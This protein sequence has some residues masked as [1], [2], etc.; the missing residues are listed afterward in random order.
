MAR[1]AP[2]AARL[3]GGRLAVPRSGDGAP[4][5]RFGVR[6]VTELRDAGRWGACARAV[7]RGGVERVHGLTPG[8]ATAGDRLW[9]GRRAE[10][11][12]P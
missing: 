4:E 11:R 7:G 12:P 8:V 2:G 1:R 5:G 3:G 10:T 9:F 6:P